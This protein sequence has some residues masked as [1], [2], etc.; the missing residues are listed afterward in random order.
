MNRLLHNED[1]TQVFWHGKW[2]EGEAG[3]HIDRYYD[4]LAG[5]GVTELFC[6]TNARRTNYTSEV[7]ES[8]FDGYDPEGPD[9]QLALRGVGGEDSLAA[10]RAG[11]GNMQAL[12]REG[13]DYPARVMALCR[14]HGI[15]PW[16]SIRMNDVHHTNL[17]EHPFHGAFWKQNPQLRRQGADGWFGT[18]Y[19]YA[20]PKVRDHFK[21]LIEESLTRYDMDGLELDFMREPYLFSVGKEAEGGK[22]LTAWMRDIRGLVETAAVRHGHPVKLG[23]R[24]PSHIETAQGLGLDA[25]VWAKE[26]L[27]DLIVPTNRWATIEFDMP[28]AQW[29][30]ALAGW[31]GTLAGGMDVSVCAHWGAKMYDVLREANDYA[32]GAAMSI[33][34][35]G[36]DALYLFNYFQPGKAG[37]VKGYQAVMKSLASPE[38]LAQLPRRHAVTWREIRAPGESFTNPLPAS[39]KSMRYSLPLGPKP[40]AGIGVRVEIVIGNAAEMEHAAPTVRLNGWTCR[41]A[42]ETAEED[43][44]RLVFEAGADAVKGDNA[45]VIDISAAAGLEIKVFGVE[46]RIAKEK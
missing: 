3:A 21:A 20:Q 45:D 4:V 27:A 40:G 36:A 11:I 30:K 33:W 28:L 2:P 46:V 29:R 25:V 23:V 19:D 17:P 16:I 9:D 39:G 41:L 14:R 8:F 44:R 13:I 15:V 34:G 6:N 26:G 12:H 37:D 35:G 7:W 43:R 24:V 18:A 10:Y 5:A 31:K 32:R 42:G 22:I 38:A 1:C